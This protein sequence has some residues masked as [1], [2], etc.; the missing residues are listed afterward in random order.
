[1]NNSSLHNLRNKYSGEG[2]LFL[3]TLIWGATFTIVKLSLADSSSML[4]VGIRFLIALIILFPFVFK[5]LKLISIA[6]FWKGILLGFILF[7][8]FAT[9]TVGLKFTT[10]TRSGFIT[11]SV[12]MF[13]PL[14][15]VIIER[16]KPSVS[17][18]L[19]AFL[20][21]C[22]LVLLSVKGTSLHN[23]IQEI[24]GNFNLG[25]FLTLICAIT[26]AIYIVY[27]D[28]YSREIETKS[29]VFLQLGTTTVSAFIFSIIF[30]VTGF[31]GLY[32]TLSNRLFLSLLYTSILAT[33][34]TTYLQT[35]YQKKVSPTMAGIIF[36]FEPVFAAII[37]ILAIH[38]KLYGFGI[39][40]CILIF[41]GLIVSELFKSTND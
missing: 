17:S 12:V 6:Q 25:D 31:E 7:S 36:S 35:E 4:F 32:F 16:R 23:L 3:I 8:S 9:Q 30:S 13:I 37:A 38:E 2:V 1:M 19:G 14:F 18:L 11:G 39:A 40:G 34:V 24:G 20:V 10:A 28:Y 29:L 15:Q 26:Y 5:K 21:I 33:L 41:C 22:G 27:L